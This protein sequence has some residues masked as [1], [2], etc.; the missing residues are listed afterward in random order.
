MTRLRSSTSKIKC[1]FISL[2]LLMRMCWP[3]P[4]A[5]FRF[6]KAIRCVM[7]DD[8]FCDI[9]AP[10]KNPLYAPR[11]HLFLYHVAEHGIGIPVERIT[12]T[13]AARLRDAKNIALFQRHQG[14]A[15]QLAVFAVGIEPA[16]RH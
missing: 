10:P 9:D 13:A 7:I 8:A 11:C 4:L 5:T 2:D 16:L 14:F 3:Q 15:D 1:Q 12:V 6:A